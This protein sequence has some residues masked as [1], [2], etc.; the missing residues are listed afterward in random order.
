LIPSLTDFVLISQD[1]VW[2]EHFSRQDEHRWLLTSLA[3]TE[4]TLSLV[5][6]G[7]SIPLSSIYDGLA[8]DPD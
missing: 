6:I 3:Q 5:S 1:R 8:I 4:D 7:S 2:V